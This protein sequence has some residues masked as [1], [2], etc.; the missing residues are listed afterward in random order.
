MAAN[1]TNRRWR[2]AGYI[3]GLVAIVVLGIALAVVW[4]SSSSMV[5]A[6]YTGTFEFTGIERFRGTEYFG[7]KWVPNPGEVGP[8]PIVIHAENG[9]VG[10][11]EFEDPKRLLERGWV[12]VP[13]PPPPP[14]WAAVAGPDPPPGLPKVV[15]YGHGDL[16]VATVHSEGVLTS[17]SVFVVN[18]KEERIAHGLPPEHEHMATRIGATRYPIS[19][20]GRRITLPLSQAEMIEALG[21]PDNERRDY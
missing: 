18:T 6:A 7:L 13:F 8:C 16:R 15:K 5:F 9:D 20:G 14:E 3:W 19:V 10:A 4:A 17:V 11:A 12:E 1:R 2:M 21:P